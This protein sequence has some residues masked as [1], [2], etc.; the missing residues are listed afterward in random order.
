MKGRFIKGHKTWNKGIPLTKETKRKISI[1]NKGGTCT[2]EQIEKRRQSILK[3]PYIPTAEHRKKVGDAHRK[4]SGI[5]ISS[6]GYRWIYQPNGHPRASRG[7]YVVEHQLVMEKYLGR[8][9]DTKSGEC[10]HH[11]DGDKLNNNINNLVLCKSISEHTLLHRNMEG[12]VMYNIKRGVIIYE[13][14]KRQ[15]T[16]RKSN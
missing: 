14:E 13:R 9:L 8:I 7:G 4:K 2:L 5:K 11:L 10:I 3:N 16:F 6:D 1:A 12:F 15:F